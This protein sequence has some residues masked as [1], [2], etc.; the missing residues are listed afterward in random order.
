MKVIDKRGP[1]TKKFRELSV[2][3]I[4]ETYET[5]GSFEYHNICMKIYAGDDDEYEYENE[6]TIR[7]NDCLT[8]FT[9]LD[10]EVTVLKAHLVV[11]G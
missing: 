4:F 8:F 3:E 10:E 2:G 9:D 7:F 1:V 5:S 6:N 11:E